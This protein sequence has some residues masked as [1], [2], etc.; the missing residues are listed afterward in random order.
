[1]IK[2]EIEIKVKKQKQRRQSIIGRPSS[3]QQKFKIKYNIYNV[4]TLR[5]T[6]IMP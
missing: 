1:M 5:R 6:K 2:I 4:T 3:D